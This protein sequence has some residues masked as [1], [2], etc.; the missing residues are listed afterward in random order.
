MW[1]MW[2]EGLEGVCSCR[3]LELVV[4]VGVAAN[5]IGE[6]PKLDT[7]MGGEG[8]MKNAEAGDCWSK[9]LTKAPED[10]SAPVMF[11]GDT[12]ADAELWMRCCDEEV[13]DK[14]DED[15][16][17]TTSSEDPNPSC[18]DRLSRESLLCGD[19][20]AAAAAID[21]GV[22][23]DLEGESCRVATTSLGL[24]LDTTSAI[25]GTVVA[26]CSGSASCST[27]SGLHPCST[28]AAMPSLTISSSRGS[29]ISTVSSRSAKVLQSGQRNPG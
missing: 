27:E 28:V 20:G 1:P 2:L 10:G 6:T 11:M 13:D 9:V 15:G 5:G 14:A 17:C 22:G 29:S 3:G 26:C 24:G 16:L 25:G 19:E 23:V 18:D 21:G 7:N 8:A 4:L 12:V